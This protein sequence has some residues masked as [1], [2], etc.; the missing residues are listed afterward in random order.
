MGL[1]ECLQ[2]EDIVYVGVIS[3]WS[4]CVQRW[5]GGQCG[6]SGWRNQDGTVG[7]ER[8]KRR[9]ERQGPAQQSPVATVKSPVHL[10]AIGSCRVHPAGEETRFRQAPWPG[11]ETCCGSQ[12]QLGGRLGSCLCSLVRGSGT[13][14]AEMRCYL[15]SRVWA[16]LV[17]KWC[18]IMNNQRKSH[19]SWNG[20]PDAMITEA[21]GPRGIP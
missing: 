13:R 10:P 21:P 6:W 4:V 17:S 14:T 11:A 8:W 2:A 9:W 16:D 18:M 19:I 15:D 7:G 3:T 5:W 20:T 12:D 1:G